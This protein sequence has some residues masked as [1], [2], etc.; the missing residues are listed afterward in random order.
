MGKT[1]VLF[2]GQGSQ[3]VGMGR[4]LAASSE[5]VSELYQRADETLG[6]SLSRICFE[7]PDDELVKTEHAQ[8]GIFLTSWAALVALKSSLTDFHFD[9]AAGLS[10]GEFTALTA[11]QAF[12]FEEGLSLTRQRGLFMQAACDQTEGAMS[13]IVGLGEEKVAEI[14]R[15][16]DVEMANLN[17]PGQIVIS[18][19]KSKVGSATAAA[20]DAGAKRAIALDVVGAY[21]SRL[22]ASAASDLDQELSGVTISPVSIP[23]LA[24]VTGLPHSEP[25]AIREQLVKQV[26]GSVRWEACMRYL[27]AQGVDCFVELGPGKALTGFMRRIDRGATVVN[28][29]DAASLANA[30]KVLGEA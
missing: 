23:V 2:S 28:V 21:H 30:V 9:Y 6:Y 1:A 24:N 29:E 11:G 5:A 14:C 18:G 19:E 7:G 16:N 22:M 27:L 13:A 12:S 10:L 26:T 20:A 4:E 8:P 17:C 25:S 3:Y 15:E